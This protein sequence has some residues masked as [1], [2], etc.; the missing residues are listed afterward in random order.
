MFEKMLLLFLGAIQQRF[1]LL[2]TILDHREAFVM[3][4][5]RA[6]GAIELC[7]PFVDRRM[8]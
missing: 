6:H 5:F 2:K 4:K 8:G 3:V 1:D 7:Q